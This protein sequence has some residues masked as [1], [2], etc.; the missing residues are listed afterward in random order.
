MHTVLL[1]LENGKIKRFMPP[2]NRLQLITMLSM[3]KFGYSSV[4]DQTLCRT[5]KTN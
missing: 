2:F 1:Q 5:R 3:I 4:S